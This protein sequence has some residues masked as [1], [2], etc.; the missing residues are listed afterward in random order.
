MEETVQVL[1]EGL[2]DP[3]GLRL[4]VA[5]QFKACLQRAR[6]EGEKWPSEAENTTRPRVDRQ[7]KKTQ[8]G[9]ETISWLVI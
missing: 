9:A 7:R 4:Q 2:R 6:R 8:Q 3:P 1:T 5:F